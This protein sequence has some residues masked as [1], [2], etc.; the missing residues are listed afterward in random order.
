MVYGKGIKRISFVVLL[1]LFSTVVFAHGKKDISEIEA[2][3]LESWQESFD[4]NHKGKGKFNIYVTATDLGGNSVVEGPH[5]LFVDPKSD[6]PVVGITHPRPDMRVV[7]NLNIVGTCIDDDAVSY[8]ELI[9]DGNKENPVRAKGKE[10][11][12]Y[13]LN[14]TKLEEGLHTIEVVGYDVNGLKGDSTMVSWNLDRRY[15]V[16]AVENLAM[17]TLVSG[18]VKLSGFVEDGNGIKSLSY[19]MDGGRFFYPIKLKNKKDKVEFEISVNTKQF[20]DGPQILWFKAVDNS[21]SVGVYS[22]LYFVDNTLP[23]VTIINPKEE[24]VNCGKFIISGYARDVMGIKSIAW[25]FGP[26]KGEFELT[27]GNP[28]WNLPVNTTGV[29]DKKRDFKVIA[30][31]IAG[32]VVTVSRKISINEDL[33]KPTIEVLDPNESTFVD[34]EEPLYVRGYAHDKD[35]IV[36]VRF[37]LDGGEWIEQQTNGPFY[38]EVAKGSDLAAG[39]HAVTVVAVDK[40]GVESVPV[41]K[42]FAARG[43]KPQFVDPKIINGKNSLPAYPGIKVHPENGDSFGVTVNCSVGITSVKSKITG[44][45]GAT[46]ETEIPI[47]AGVSSVPITFALNKDLPQGI[48]RVA[49]EA[50]DTLG[51]V[52]DYKTFIN[53]TNTTTVKDVDPAVVFDDS[54]IDENGMVANN[55]E[56]PVTGYF[57]GGNAKTVE[58]VPANA[59]ARAT[60]KN[61]IITLVPGE[62]TGIS[63]EVVVKVTTDMNKVYQSRP[64]RLKNE[65]AL[66]R[67]RLA[68][69]SDSKAVDGSGG[70]LKING[71]VASD[72]GLASL[73]YRIFS[74]K[75]VMN[76]PLIKSLE[77]VKASEPIAIDSQR[78]FS[79]NFDA[80]SEE[81]GPGVYIIEV[82]AVGSSGEPVATAVCIKNIPQLEEGAPAPAA[83]M[84]AWADGTD[85]YCAF[86]SQGEIDREFQV[87]KREDMTAGTV[88]LTAQ[89]VN[90]ADQKVYP[91]KFTTSK[92]A[93][94]TGRI[95]NVE[96]EAYAS[97]MKVNVEQG[98]SVTMIAEVESPSPL[99]AVTYEITGERVPGG[100]P[101]S[102][103]AATFALKEGTTNVYTI[104]VPLANLPVRYNKVKITAKAGTISKELVG[105]IMIARPVD[106]K[107]VDDRR[108]V[109]V[110][111]GTGV[112][113]D[114]ETG[115][116]LAAG[117]VVY[118]YANVGTLEGNPMFAQTMDGLE[119]SVS[120]Q[121][122]NL[123]LVKVTKDGTYQG[124]QVR[125]KN[126]DGVNFQS[127]AVTLIADTGAPD[128]KIVSPTQQSWAKN[129]VR[130]SGTAAD[131]SGIKAVEYSLDRGETWQAANVSGP[132]TGVTFNASINLKN[133]ED[134]FYCIDVRALDAAG[135]PSYARCSVIKD[136]VPPEVTLVCPTDESIINGDNEISF[137]VVDNGSFEK[138]YYVAPP[139]KS[140][141]EKIDLFA[142]QEGGSTPYVVTHIGTEK[143]PNNDAMSFEFADAAGN[144]T[145]IDAWKFL[146]DNESDYPV[147][148][149]HLPIEDEVITRDFTISGVV[150]DDDGSADIY[151]KIDKGEFQKLP[152]PSSSFAI[153]IDFSTMVDNEHVI[154]VYAVDPNGVKGP[155]AER[156][157]RV[158]TEEPRGSVEKPTIEDAVREVIT[159]SGNAMDKNGIE[160]VYVSLDNGNSYNLANGTT[161]WTYTVDT[162]AIPNGTGVVFTKIVDKYGIT[163]L[164]SSLI[165]IDNEKPKMILDYPIDDSTT[166]GNLFFSGYAFDNVAITEM[167]ATI[168]SLDG[169]EVPAKMKK[170]DFDLERV[171]SNVLDISS[172]NNGSYNVEVTASDKAGNTTHLSRNII[173]NKNKPMAT[174]ELL[175][176]LNGEQKQ[177]VFNIYGSA[178]TDTKVESLSLYVDNKFI[179]ETEL[180]NAGYFMFKMGPES[181]EEGKHNY[182]VDAK[183]EGG[184]IIRSRVQSIV[185]NPV[186]PWVTIDNFAY[187]DF[188]I[189]RPFV[190]GHAG[191]ALDE[192]ELL[193]SKMKGATKE[194]KAI[195]A[196]KAVEKVEVSFDNGKTFE[197]VSKKEK[198]M[199]R[200]ENQDIAEGFHFMLVRAT[201][202]NGETAIERC[203]IQ[204]DNTRPTIQLISP[205]VGGHY[206]Q[207][208]V[209]SGLSHDDVGLNSVKMTLRKGDKSSWEVPTFIKGLYFDWKFWGATLFDIGVGLTFFDDIVKVQFEW[210]QFTQEQRARSLQLLG[211]EASEMRYGGDNVMGIKIL[212]N[213]AQLP[214][215]VI[216]GRDFE[217]LSATLALGATFTYFNQTNSGEGQ[218]LSAL[219]TQIEFPRLHFKELKAFSTMALYYE[220]SLWFIPTDVSG[221]DW[222][223]KYAWQNSIGVRLNVF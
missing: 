6:L 131:P 69:A 138:A 48:V 191:Y 172:L 29:K 161:N 128:I 23:E 49:I 167:Y 209:F 177:G 157:F 37:K 72:G 93:K 65:G 205:V 54:T 186:G 56:N 21:G 103:G 97:G 181:I 164:Y 9:L 61:N 122:P 117:S 12:A 119:L 145:V 76:G 7:G 47:K 148:S 11:W 96:G 91:T 22:F 50:T 124:V 183:V 218:F 55:K 53:L 156:K 199:Y 35:G 25:E 108:T 82:T 134:G 146:I 189:D 68:G 219:L 198:W 83:P 201:M 210:G 207:E 73:T 92:A 132:K 44:G 57:M 95:V 140:T 15:P 107:M 81:N 116:G 150:L 59:F 169:K 139:T 175:Y 180:T 195:V 51:R 141:K 115:Y 127:A 74:A 130:L 158:S 52:S 33:N 171:I 75:A 123:I 28:F 126:S 85:T 10:F 26:D 86:V 111:E 203:I 222:T 152:E 63:D 46:I 220:G 40:C 98:G 67:L 34:A 19:S 13:F 176:P 60:L 64:L 144:I 192:E 45:R 17:G 104:S 18:N 135:N 114:K 77:P 215:S 94:M 38:G 118:F 206:N 216:F 102:N 89:V 153:P 166:A 31:D 174:V 79:I 208:L 133:E 197:N 170:V 70:S 194:D 165:N 188:A 211:M 173:L 109:Y 151:Y 159:I 214:F 1:M 2:S 184:Q 185:Y 113:Y 162:R 202:K 101:A 66:P 125:V 5:N 168:S 204:V 147:A 200:V 30:T 143:Q 160:A 58:I 99:T 20:E 43:A 110:I 223:K 71:A 213:V 36:L 112:N 90:Q 87:F 78:Q 4:L 136:T 212:A 8:V 155:V 32:N 196:A 217:A 62:I 120:E 182:R 3:N 149:I 39:K 24:D 106:T 129:G 41:V 105:T 190:R 193:K 137:T 27:P 187:G 121:N 142:Q 84:F 221:L 154:S 80:T 178:S 16:T 14:T 179:A 88:P 163:G 42:E 100:L